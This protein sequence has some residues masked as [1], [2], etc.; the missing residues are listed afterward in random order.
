M[1]QWIV[2]SFIL[3]MIAIHGAYI[4]VHM[5]LLYYKNSTFSFMHGLSV[6]FLLQSQ[7]LMYVNKNSYNIC[8]WICKTVPNGTRIESHL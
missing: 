3:M 5:Y 2:N 1:L 4:Y 8:D 6:S 7:N